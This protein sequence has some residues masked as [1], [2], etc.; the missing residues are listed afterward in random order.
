MVK[1]GLRAAGYGSPSGPAFDAALLGR[2]PADFF[3]DG[4]FALEQGFVF[5]AMVL[6]ACTVFVI[7]RRFV[8]AAGWCLAGSVLAAIGLVHSYQFTPGDTA[9]PSEFTPAWEWCAGYA[10]MAACF[11]SVRYV[12]KPEPP[13]P[14][15]TAP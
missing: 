13:K 8:A 3:A 12:A 10:M 9:L 6:A 11:L 7:E 14:E 4:A 5:S 1:T 15:D 2:F